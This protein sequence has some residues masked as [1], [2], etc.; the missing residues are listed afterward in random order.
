MARRVFWRV[1]VVKGLG[2]A[3]CLSALC[4]E[5]RAAARPSLDER[6]MVEGGLEEGLGPSK[7]ESG[8]WEQEW[9]LKAGMGMGSNLH[10]RDS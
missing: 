7:F 2:G 9:E 6:C 8:V 3:A 4:S 1:G 5:R 10:L